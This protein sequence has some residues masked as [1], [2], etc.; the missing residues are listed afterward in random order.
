MAKDKREDPIV[1]S[2]RDI[3]LIS[4]PVTKDG[5]DFRTADG[6]RM[7]HPPKQVYLVNAAYELDDVETQADGSLWWHYRQVTA[8][9][10][11]PSS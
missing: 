10:D 11:P 3:A 5:R 7:S 1:I 9:N 2:A 8:K 4:L 6:R